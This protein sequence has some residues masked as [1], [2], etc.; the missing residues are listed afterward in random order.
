MNAELIKF[1]GEWH[2][3]CVK[4]KAHYGAES[5]VG[6][7]AFYYRDATRPDGLC[8]KCKECFR[9]KKQ[10]PEAIYRR[11][12]RYVAKNP[13]KHKARALFRAA[14]LSGKILRATSCEVCGACSSI[15]G[16]H[17]DY[18]KPLEVIWLC[19]PCHHAEHA[20]EKANP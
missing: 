7:T 17:P 9:K 8:N 20:K 16:H 1:N 14:I 6:L 13:I 19:R 2:K 11:H 5:L 15:Q 18:N 3:D 12:I 10:R 4:C